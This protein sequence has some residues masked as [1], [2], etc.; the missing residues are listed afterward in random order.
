MREYIFL[1]NMTRRPSKDLILQ[2][3]Q[4]STVFYNF[5]IIKNRNLLQKNL[6]SGLVF[7]FLGGF[8]GV[9]YV[10][11][12]FRTLFNYF[13]GTKLKAYTSSMIVFLPIQKLWVSCF[14]SGK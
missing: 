4:Q 1:I 8:F 2:Y 7:C 5:M 12:Y 10:L 13:Q 9:Y 11:L 6:S 14:I 3:K